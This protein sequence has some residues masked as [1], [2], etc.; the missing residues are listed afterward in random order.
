[1]LRIVNIVPFSM[2]GETQQDSEPNLAV[3]PASP[4]DM[5]ATAF[6]PAPMG[7]NN[8]PLY[9]S[10]DGGNTWCLYTVIPGNN[11]ASGTD[12]ITVGFATSSGM[13]YAGMLN[14][15]TGRMQILRASAP[16]L[17]L[18]MTPLG[19]VDRA[20]EDQPWVVAGSVV[21]NGASVDRVFVGNNDGNQPDMT[22]TVDVSQDAA[23][24]GPVQF[25]PIQVEQRTTNG[26]GDLSAIRIA[27]HANGTIYAAFQ[28]LDD[29]AEHIVVTRDDNWGSGQTPFTALTE[30]GTQPV[31]GVRAVPNVF[32][33]S[34][35]EMGQ[36]RLGNDLAIAVH[37]RDS[38]TV[39][40]AHCDGLTGP[41]LSTLHVLRST[42]GGKTWPEEL[43]TPIANVTNPALAFN[44]DG[45]LGVAYQ[46]YTGMTW[47]TKLDLMSPE[48]W[49]SVTLHT[50]PADFPVRA[51]LLPYLGDYIRLLGVG[52]DFYGV[53]CG[54]NT[55][56]P[57]NFPN[58]VIYQ[59]AADWTNRQ[60]L[61]I[62]G[63]THVDVSIDPFFFHWSP[64]LPPR[65]RPDVQKS[66]IKARRPKKTTDPKRKRPAKRPKKTMH[67]KTKRPARR[68][69]KATNP[70]RKRPSK[71]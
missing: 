66:V 1:M 48:G 45:L 4:M 15:T 65:Y 17:G 67:A 29:N 2:S 41:N 69:K 12:D 3:N 55:P 49:T 18:P 50:A 13:L 40:L 64:L 43:R 44:E 59:R 28:H 71:R 62:D 6:T 26:N 58:G 34:Q 16:I 22:A 36:E 70:K 61:S 10:T 20:W 68:P 5:V 30:G 31:A 46:Q 24:P 63:I 27:V 35:L 53:F 54:N 33:P 25:N 32:I 60:L 21:V 57:A 51:G 42:D 9:V 7:G 37:P 19:G 39:C 11:P 56:D 38:N 14:G 23:G 52:K 47:D 8:A